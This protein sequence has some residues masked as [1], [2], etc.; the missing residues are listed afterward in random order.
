MEISIDQDPP[1][2][3][4]IEDE[5]KMLTERIKFLVST[6]NKFFNYTVGPIVGS[7]IISLYRLISYKPQI[8]QT[9]NVILSSVA[10]VLFFLNLFVTIYTKIEIKRKVSLKNS[11]QPLDQSNAAEVVE[12]CKVHPAIEAYRLKVVALSRDIIQIELEAIQDWF[13]E[14]IE[15]TA[16]KKLQSPGAIQDSSKE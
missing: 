11:L 7:G 4:E 13:T 16:L 1:T 6:R 3:A 9:L 10:I 8:S 5:K 2:Q 15:Q 14:S 12:F